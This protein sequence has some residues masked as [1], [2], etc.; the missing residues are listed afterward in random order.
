MSDELFEKVLEDLRAIPTSLPLTIVPNGVNEPFMDRKMFPRLRRINEVLPA[1]KLLIFTNL[2]V[3]R[4]GFFD[5]LSKIRNISRIN[6]SFNA[7]N[8]EEYKSAMGISFE[9]TVNALRELMRHQKRARF[10]REPVLLSRVADGT[11]ADE[12]Y[13]RD[14]QSLFNEFVLDRDYSVSVK[15]AADW[16]GES[17]NVTSKVEGA[18]PCSQWLA[19][20]VHNDGTVP[21]CC[22]DASG[23]FKL[24]N[25]SETHVLDLYNSPGFRSLRET[26]LRREFASPCHTCSLV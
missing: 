17:A 4:S 16:L 5:E 6:V 24:G 22:M 11:D 2:N 8:E 1:A 10:V 9:R 23:Q 20:T 21:H 19:L 26:A 7:A 14:C 15:R 25:A 18:L 3:V 12:R 13:K